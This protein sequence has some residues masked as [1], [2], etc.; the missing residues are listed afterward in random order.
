MKVAASTRVV[1]QTMAVTK[2]KV[3]GDSVQI[4]SLQRGLLATLNTF[5]GRG[6]FVFVIIY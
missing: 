6:N 2:I 4:I 5:D 1:H 3:F